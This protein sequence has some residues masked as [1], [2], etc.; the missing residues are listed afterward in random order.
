MGWKR[1]DDISLFCPDC[2]RKHYILR[3][4]AIPVVSPLDCTW[5][6]FRTVIRA[7]WRETTKAANW[8]MT[9]LWGH[10]V[11]RSGEEKMPPMARLYLYP[12]ARIKFPLLPPTAVASL[13]QAVQKKY[14]AK[15]YEVLWTNAASL[16]THRYPTPFSLPNQSWSVSIENNHA[17]IS[18]RIGDTRLRARLKGGARFLRQLAAARSI[19]SGHA[20]QGELAIY[21]KGNDLMTKMVAWLPRDTLKAGLEKTGTLS[22]RTG[23]EWILAGFDSKNERAWI[24]NGDQTRR[25]V[26]EYLRQLQRWSQDQKAEQR[27]VPAFAQRRTEAVGKYNRRMSAV[28]NEISAMLVNY[29]V[30]RKFQT[31]RYDD[32]E[33]GFLQQFQWSRLAELISQKCDVAGIIFEHARAPVSPQ[34]SSPLADV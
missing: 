18:I 32:S 9:E 28:C 15:R 25:W 17:V 7:M 20:V 3:A 24:Y 5:E 16:P 31:L 33:T 22:V 27:P 29:A 2:W 8:M 34:S 19:A 11:R 4:I 21:E 26:A 6:E 30:R 14:R 1:R 13:E 23:K 12:D 10:D